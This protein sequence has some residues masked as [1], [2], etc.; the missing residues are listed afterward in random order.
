M[1]PLRRLTLVLPRPYGVGGQRRLAS[2]WPPGLEPLVERRLWDSATPGPLAVAALTPPS[3]EVEFI[4]EA[5]QSIDW[6]REY[7]LVGIYAVTHQAPR[8]Y[9]L[10][11][12]FARKGARVVL[13]GVHPTLLPQEAA[14]YAD[15]VVVGEAEDVWEQVVEDYLC[16]RLGGV[17]RAPAPPSL[18]RSPV[19][20]FDL[21][22]PGLYR[23]LPIQT[24]RGCPHACEFCNLPELYGRG[25]RAKEIGAVVNEIAVLRRF[26]P[27]STIYLTD[28]NL[29]VSHARSRELLQALLPLGLRLYANS[30]LSLA[31]DGGLL[32]LAARA[33]LRQVLVGLESLS[34]ASLTGL[35][36]SGFKHRRLK[37]YGQAVRRIQ[38]RG[39]GVVGSFVLG[40]DGDD[41][42]IFEA[43]LDFAASTRLY[44]VSLTVQTPFPGT[45]L[46]R[47]LEAEGRVL[48]RD[49]NLYT[50]FE[51]V[52]QPLNLTVE[53]LRRGHAWLIEQ[54]NRPD[55]LA[56][57]AAFFL[58][59]QR[60]TARGATG[61]GGAR[62]AAA[63]GGQP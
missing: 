35:G 19:P 57:R 33:G 44:G 36:P 28:D 26:H 1:T 25:Y 41:A 58:E 29:F 45:R 62:P 23:V 4:D 12:R 54:L 61:A 22:E 13:G 42:S 59:V 24:A 10:A 52:M 17:Y 39:I 43:V 7:G 49:W 56:Q 11:R 34:P 21:I 47:R 14:G 55:L 32:E 48:T 51:V 6:D 31:D 27:R 16:D 18:A 15:A 20:R 3:M 53:G 30:D 46:F 50:I 9:D 60:R 40:L 63:G 2:H 5:R 8:A 37:E 38:S